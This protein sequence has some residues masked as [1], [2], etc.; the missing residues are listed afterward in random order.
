M[1]R[2]N[3]LTKAVAMTPWFV[4]NSW[5]FV[6]TKRF[7]SKVEFITGLIPAWFRFTCL[8]YKDFKGYQL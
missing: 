1:N 3:A 8:T 5:S 6:V 2:L 4:K 7:S